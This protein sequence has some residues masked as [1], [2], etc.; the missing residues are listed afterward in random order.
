MSTQLAIQGV[1]WRSSWHKT[2]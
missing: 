2:A 1:A